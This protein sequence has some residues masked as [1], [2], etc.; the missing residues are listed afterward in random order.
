MSEPIDESHAGTA[1]RNWN[2]NWEGHR[3]QQLLHWAQLPL[4][5]K[6]EWLE[7]AEEIAMNLAASRKAQTEQSSESQA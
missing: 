1:D 5:E 4:E 6:L 7:E 3:R 2:C